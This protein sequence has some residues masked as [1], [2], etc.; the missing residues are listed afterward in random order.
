MKKPY[1]SPELTRYGD[2]ET[3]TKFTVKDLQ[4]ANKLVEHLGE[5][6]LNIFASFGGF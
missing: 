1:K 4:D 5:G 3:I 2:V 6:S